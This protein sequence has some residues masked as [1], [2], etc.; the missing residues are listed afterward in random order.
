M[1]KKQAAQE[2]VGLRKTTQMTQKAFAEAFDI[3]VRT[4]QN[5]EEGIN[6]PNRYTK[7]CLT[8]HVNRWLNEKNK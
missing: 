5:W 2:I 3:P 8:E 7:R 6:A 4:L 1:D